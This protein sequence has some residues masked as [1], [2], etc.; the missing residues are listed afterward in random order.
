MWGWLSVPEE[1]L[2][3][4]H[5]SDLGLWRPRT[6]NERNQG[7][8]GPQGWLSDPWEADTGV[9]AMALGTTG[10]GNSPGIF[11]RSSSEADM[12]SL[13]WISLSQGT[14]LTA[15]VKCPRQ[16]RPIHSFIHSILATCQARSLALQVSHEGSKQRPALMEFTYQKGN[17]QQNNKQTNMEPSPVEWCQEER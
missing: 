6:G 16:H 10:H 15:C 11:S 4:V 2:L 5:S 17:R 13:K 7:P 9:A 3:L 8:N 14:F 1:L 12:W